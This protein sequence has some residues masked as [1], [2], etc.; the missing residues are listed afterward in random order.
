MLESESAGNN[1][2]QEK[3]N[4]KNI[5]L[6]IFYLCRSLLLQTIFYCI[7]CGV[8]ILAAKF[9]LIPQLNLTNEAPK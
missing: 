1:T 2:T 8:I 9:S 7:Y 4:C 6:L 3:W 5:R